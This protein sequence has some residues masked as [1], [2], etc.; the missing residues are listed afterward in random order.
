MRMSIR[1]P[2]CSGVTVSY[3]LIDCIYTDKHAGQKP[4]RPLPPHL[5]GRV[6]CNPLQVLNLQLCMQIPPSRALTPNTNHGVTRQ[7][8]KSIYPILPQ[9]CSRANPSPTRPAASSSPPPP[10][11]LYLKGAPKHLVVEKGNDGNEIT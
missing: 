10:K 4:R 2:L 9:H 7:R 3:S 1:R 6:F 5:P 8:V 11:I